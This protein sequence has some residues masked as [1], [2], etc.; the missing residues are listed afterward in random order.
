VTNGRSPP[1]FH[2]ENALERFARVGDLFE[3]VL[4]LKQNLEDALQK[5]GDLVRTPGGS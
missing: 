3:P 1:Q 2:L 5:L 4:T